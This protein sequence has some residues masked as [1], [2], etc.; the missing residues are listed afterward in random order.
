M[1]ILLLKTN[2]LSHPPQVAA[3]PLHKSEYS[4]REYKGAI[5][6]SEEHG[7]LL[8]IQKCKGQLFT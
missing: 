7:K 2:L 6:W 1:C 3:E 5:G 8:R 4:G